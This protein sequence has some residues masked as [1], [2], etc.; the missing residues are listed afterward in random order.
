MDGGSVKVGLAGQVRRDHS[1]HGGRAIGE[2]PGLHGHALGF[3]VG[4]ELRT[5]GALPTAI[6]PFQHNQ[7]SAA[8]VLPAAAR[9]DGGHG[10]TEPHAPLPQPHS[11]SAYS[12]RGASQS[13]RQRQH[14][15]GGGQCRRRPTLIV[16]PQQRHPRR[17]W[18]EFESGPGEGPTLRVT[19]RTAMGLLGHGS[20]TYRSLHP[21]KIHSFCNCIQDKLVYRFL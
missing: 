20:N 9:V 19:L 3:Q 21:L 14:H 12:Q 16:T 10:W 7:R 15:R 5:L 4:R 6:K 18:R 8:S 1:T 2:P 17:R 13:N 11:G